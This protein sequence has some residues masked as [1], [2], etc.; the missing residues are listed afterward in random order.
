MQIGAAPLSHEYKVDAGKKADCVTLEK[1]LDGCAGGHFERSQ[2]EERSVFLEVG[3]KYGSSGSY[4][5]TLQGPISVV[6]LLF[7]VRYLYRT[8]FPRDTSTISI[9][10]IRWFWPAN[11]VKSSVRE[12]RLLWARRIVQFFSLQK[13]GS[14]IP[15]EGSRLPTHKARSRVSWIRDIESFLFISWKEFKQKATVT[16]LTYAF[17]RNETYNAV[18]DKQYFLSFHVELDPIQEVADTTSITIVLSGTSISLIFTGN[19]FYQNF[20]STWL[21]FEVRKHLYGIHSIHKD[22]D[23]RKQSY[24]K[25]SSMG[26][27]PVAKLLRPLRIFH[28]QLKRLFPAGTNSSR[29][30]YQHMSVNPNTLVCKEFSRS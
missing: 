29:V 16:L 2:Y 21:T 15:D 18:S 9:L 6:L 17:T 20:G 30:V 26:I 3:L 27:Q 8:L 11:S 1:F 7:S 12:D 23:C 4:L 5:F 22:W 10:G 28:P 24:I 14:L 19:I 25:C 13:W